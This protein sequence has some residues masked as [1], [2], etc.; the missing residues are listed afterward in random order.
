MIEKCLKLTIFIVIHYQHWK[1]QQEYQEKLSTEVSEKPKRK[2]KAK[3]KPKGLGDKIEAVT[4]ATGI[5]AV[6]DKV[7]EVTGTDCG[8]AKRK[9]YLNNRFPSYTNMSKEDQVIWLEQLQPKFQAGARVNYAFQET[10]IDVYQR[11]F[12]IRR[13]KT[14]CGDCFLGYL[15]QLEKAYHASCES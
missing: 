4:K 14:N 2:S 5:K 1:M 9:A 12:G 3:S 13:K 10:V 11:T 8:C 15:S 6:V 7:A